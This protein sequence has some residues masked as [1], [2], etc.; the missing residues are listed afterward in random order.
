MSTYKIIDADTVTTSGSFGAEYT[1]TRHGSSFRV[2][3]VN[4]MVKAY[5]RGFA[6]GR[7]FETLAEVEKAYKGLRGVAGAF[8]MS[9][10]D[11][12]ASAHVNPLDPSTKV[13]TT[14]I[15]GWCGRDVYVR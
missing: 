15:C 13:H 12:P 3:V 6:V 14:A 1:V 9:G 11:C 7:D 8:E 5:S 4:A 10:R 2:Y